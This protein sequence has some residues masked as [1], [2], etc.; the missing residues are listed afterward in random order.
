[1]DAPPFAHK[2]FCPRLKATTEDS[3]IGDD[4]LNLFASIPR[5]EVGRRMFIMKHADH[6]S[7]ESAH[8]GHE[9]ILA[10]LKADSDTLPSQ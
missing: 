6:N 3:S 5:M 1:M 9:E 8:F 10:C 7:E 4:D 2:A